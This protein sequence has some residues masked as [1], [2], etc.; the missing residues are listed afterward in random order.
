MIGIAAIYA[1]KSTEQVGVSDEARSVTRQIEHASAYASRKGWAVAPEHVYVDDGISGAEFATRP[2]FLRLMNALKPRPSFDVLVMSEQSR[3]GRESIE[4]AYALKQLIAAGVRVWVYLDDR[5]LSLESATDKIMLSLAAFA[6]ELERERARQRT[7]DALARKA[8]A[9]FVTGGAVFGYRNER[10]AAG[11]RRVVELGDADVVRQIFALAAS[12][13]GLTSI[14]KQLNANRARSPRA[15]QGRP[16]GW[17]PSSVREVLHRRLYVGEVVWNKTRKRNAAGI[18]DATDRPESEWLRVDC[19][20]LAI[21]S[22][23]EW[24][25]AH[26]MMERARDRYA[27]RSVVRGASWGIEPRYLLTGLMR[28]GVCGGGI[29][30]RSRNHGSA[31][32]VFYSC[33]VRTRRGPSM[34][35]NALAVPM[36]PSNAAVIETLQRSLLNPVVLS[37]AVQRA[38]AEL[39]VPA[40]D[41]NPIRSALASVALEIERLTTAIA[42]G[43]PLEPLMLALRERERRRTQ[44]RADLERR[45]AAIGDVP[46]A[47]DVFADLN[48]R[49]DEWRDIFLDAEGPGVVAANR[50]LRQLVVDRLVLHPESDHYRFIGAGT[51]EPLLSGVMSL[52]TV[53]GVPNG[54]RFTVMPPIPLTGILPKAA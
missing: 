29:E 45:A 50:L 6:D 18:V 17:A 9:G 46:V 31:R 2:G 12:G 39:T 53:N 40:Q 13:V 4:T 54:N 19:P 51:L 35:S 3:L 8:R 34:C 7:Y 32:Q 52:V 26:A 27:R 14:A 37:A 41:I 15:Q 20:E 38:V 10:S 48:A 47:A 22:A 42:T 5:E 49:L 44:L 16:S 21:V 11:V 43:G 24:D 28:C 25:A 33:S 36:R 30:A 23:A 1:R